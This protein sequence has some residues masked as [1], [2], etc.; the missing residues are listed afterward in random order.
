MSYAFGLSHAAVNERSARAC[1]GNSDWLLHEHS[2]VR[3]RVINQHGYSAIVKGLVFLINI[4]FALIQEKYIQ[5][6]KR[7]QKNNI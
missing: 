2:C 5:K 7:F 4:K 3:V 6:S 1:D